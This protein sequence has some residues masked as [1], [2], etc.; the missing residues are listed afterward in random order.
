MSPD[1]GSPYSKW[2]SPIMTYDEC[3]DM[4]A[5]MFTRVMSKRKTYISKFDAFSIPIIME[6]IPKQL[7]NMSINSGINKLIFSDYFDKLSNIYYDD[8]IK[9][10]NPLENRSTLN[11]PVIDAHSNVFQSKLI[12]KKLWIG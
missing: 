3:K 11:I 12:Y 8:L 10:N 2:R 9:I 4:S 1:D 7:L 5:N 6:K